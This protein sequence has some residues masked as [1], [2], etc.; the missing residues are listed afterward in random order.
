VKALWNALTPL[1]RNEWIC[2]ITSV[3]KKETRKQH[4]KRACSDIGAGKRRPCCGLAVRIVEVTK[5]CKS[6][7]F[8][9]YAVSAKAGKRHI[10]M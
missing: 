10:L 9:A 2:W 7:G 8:C 3:K 4:A 6:F 5:A 1:A